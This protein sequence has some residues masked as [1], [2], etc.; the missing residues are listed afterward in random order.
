MTP[1][2]TVRTARR[3]GDTVR[4]DGIANREQYVTALFSS[5]AYEFKSESSE[6]KQ[7]IPPLGII[8]GL[9]VASHCLYFSGSLVVF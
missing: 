9:L 5:L 4:V 1:S 7:G 6:S 8:S 3:A 2:Q